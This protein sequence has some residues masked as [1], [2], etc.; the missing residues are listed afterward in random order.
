MHEMMLVF[1]KEWKLFF[2]NSP[3]TYKTATPSSRTA[4]NSN[5]MRALTDKNII[6]SWIEEYNKRIQ[7]VKKHFNTSSAG[8]CRFLDVNVKFFW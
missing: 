1:E 2:S 4:N 7:K 5:V 8:N 3:V 6:H